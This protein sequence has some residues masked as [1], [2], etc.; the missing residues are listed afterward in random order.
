MVILILEYNFNL[1]TKCRKICSCKVFFLFSILFLQ[2][3]EVIKKWQFFSDIVVAITEWYYIPKLLF[4]TY[5]YIEIWNNF[6]IDISH[7]K[8]DLNSKCLYRSV[9]HRRFRNRYSE[10]HK[11]TS[12]HFCIQPAKERPADR[13]ISLAIACSFPWSLLTLKRS[14]FVPLDKILRVP[15]DHQHHYQRSHRPGGASVYNLSTSAYQSASAFSERRAFF[16]P[17]YLR[18]VSRTPL[19]A[20]ATQRGK[21]RPCPVGSL[22]DARIRQHRPRR[23]Y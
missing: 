16:W 19:L 9:F 18:T 3:T 15:R 23:S 17:H 5:Y 21:F 4:Y 7:P 1:T 22:F 2:V 8:L 12:T 20:V 6:F 14:I 10:W 11:R 13:P